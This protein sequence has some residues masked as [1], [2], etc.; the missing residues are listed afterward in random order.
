MTAIRANPGYCLPTQSPVYCTAGAILTQATARREVHV[1]LMQVALCCRGARL[2]EHD[3]GCVL[4]DAIAL[5]SR[6]HLCTQSSAS[7]PYSCRDSV[8]SGRCAAGKV[9]HATAP[10]ADESDM[11]SEACRAR[12]PADTYGRHTPAS[13]V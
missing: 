11:L 7:L 6:M 5:L 8:I 12:A 13:G 4:H 10:P 2:V 9:L 3:L 1:P